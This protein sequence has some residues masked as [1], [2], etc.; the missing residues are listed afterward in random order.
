MPF[1]SIHSVDKRWNGTNRDCLAYFHRHRT[2]VL[3]SDGLRQMGEE[4]FK[5]VNEHLELLMLRITPSKR[6]Q[7]VTTEC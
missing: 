3:L 1:Q 5:E 4:K 2:M 6:S 7:T